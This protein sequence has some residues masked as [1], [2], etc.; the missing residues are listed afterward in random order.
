M[1]NDSS[2]FTELEQLRSN[3]KV[4]LGDGCTLDIAGEGTVNMDLLLDDGT[5]RSCTLKKV[6]YVLELA[7]N[8]INVSRA[9]DVERTVHFDDSS[10]EFLNEKNEIFT[11]GAREG[12]LYY[13]KFANTVGVLAIFLSKSKQS[14]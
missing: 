5:R 11:F 14:H 6:L 9:G 1:C 13:L 4:T 2:M 12:R 10:C 7:Y 8:L 3:D